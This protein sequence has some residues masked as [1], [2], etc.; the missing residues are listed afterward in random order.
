M[1]QRY[2]IKEL[3]AALAIINMCMRGI[4]AMPDD[5]YSP[6]DEYILDAYQALDEAYCCLRDAVKTINE[7]VAR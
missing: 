5:F 6:V 2:E 3:D 4:D 1:T 7:G